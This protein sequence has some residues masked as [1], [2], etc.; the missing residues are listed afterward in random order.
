MSALAHSMRLPTLL[1]LLLLLLLSLPLAFLCP[2][3]HGPAPADSGFSLSDSLV[4]QA[5]AELE[6]PAVR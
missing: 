3:P 2:S 4:E 1:L 5:L 6:H